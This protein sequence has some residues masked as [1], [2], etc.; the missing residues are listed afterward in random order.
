M[1]STAKSAETLEGLAVLLVEDNFLNGIALRHALQNLGCDVVG[2]VASV[3]RGLELVASVKVDV[4]VLDINI[5]GGTVEP[6]AQKLRNL[7]RK[8]VFVTGYGSPQNLSEPLRQIP[9]LRKPVSMYELREVLC[10]FVR[11]SSESAE[12]QPA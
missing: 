10:R 11:E 7:H 4:G 2:P 1:T 12:N 3:T 8:F 9:R 5:I 6:I